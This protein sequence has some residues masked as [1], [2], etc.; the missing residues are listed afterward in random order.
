M[1]AEPDINAF[2][3]REGGI[4]TRVAV[5]VHGSAGWVGVVG[6]CES[7]RTALAALSAEYAVNTMSFNIFV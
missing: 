3:F 4:L 5:L 1:R 2:F 7:H 6:A